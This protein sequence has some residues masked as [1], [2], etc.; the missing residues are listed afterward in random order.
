MSRLRLINA[1][2]GVKAQA[3]GRIL[4]TLAVPIRNI[5]GEVSGDIWE[6]VEEIRL[7]QNRP[8]MLV[9]DRGDC[10]V[11]PRGAITPSAFKAYIVTGDDMKK[12]L[13]LM[14]SCSI[15]SLE[16]E[17]RQ[18][19]LT[20]KGG[21]RVGL[22]GKTVLEQGRVRLLKHITGLNLRLA[23]ELPGV[24]DKAIPY[25]I[26]ETKN[27][28]YHSLLVSPPQGGKTTLL[29]DIIRQISHG[30]PSLGFSG[31][32]VG[33][34]DE[35]S[36]IGGCCAGVPQMDLGPRTDILD[37]CPKAEGMMMLI[38][39]MSPQVIATDELGRG[40][41]AEAVEE[42]LHAG[43]KLLTTAHGY[44]LASLRRRPILSHILAERI[45]ERIL[46]LGFSLGVGTL[47]A[48]IDGESNS[49]L[50]S[51]PLR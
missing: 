48:V 12:T 46:F 41:D 16:E 9:L 49:S 37:G 27:T 4:N 1:E 17:L 2:S 36:E 6:G 15:Y 21:H 11:D 45:F 39:S 31:L 34:V 8:L 30:I 22:T 7:R 40:E 51:K 24:A 38:R 50:L 47:E 43:A 33:V 5:L 18:G 20:L 42:A 44:S 26:D 13:Q 19:F 10:F 28:I 14:S 29:R 3:R 35:R 23:R 32:K 25:L